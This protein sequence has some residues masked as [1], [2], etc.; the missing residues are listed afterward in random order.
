MVVRSCS[1]GPTDRRRGSGLCAP[2]PRRQGQAR[3]V[4]KAGARDTPPESPRRLQVLGWENVAKK[5]S[6][7]EGKGTFQRSHESGS[8]LCGF[9]PRPQ[10]NKEVKRSRPQL[11]I[12]DTHRVTKWEWDASLADDLSESR[13]NQAETKYP[14]YKEFCVREILSGEQG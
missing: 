14:T 3:Q 2:L 9:G 13:S 12:G 4:R 7:S 6:P 5:Q 8:A 10:S 1:C 11:E